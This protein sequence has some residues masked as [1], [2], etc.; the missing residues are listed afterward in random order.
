MTLKDNYYWNHK[1]VL[2][3]K[4]EGGLSSSIWA[5]QGINTPSILWMGG[6]RGSGTRASRKNLTE[7]G[8]SPP[9]RE[10]PPASC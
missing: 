5:S 3:G 2:L 6:G 7:E 1:L 4:T 8:G 10:G 9:T